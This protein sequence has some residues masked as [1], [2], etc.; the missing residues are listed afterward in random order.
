MKLTY[1]EIY[2]RLNAIDAITPV[3]STVSAQTRTS[4]LLIRVALRRK[5]D[6]YESI[7]QDTLR[8]IKK[9]EEFKEFDTLAAKLQRAEGVMERVKAHDDFSGEGKQPRRPTDK[10]IE[11]ARDTL[12][13]QAEVLRLE[14]AIKAQWIPARR[15]AAMSE[16]EVEYTPLT[17]SELEEIVGA[18]GCEILPSGV[19]APIVLTYIATLTE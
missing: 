13:T 7:N 18:I 15:K 4:L 2:N 10:E 9:Q 6:E 3:C 12:A 5:A 14:E 19:H 11:E 1:N 17:R 16:T 8:E